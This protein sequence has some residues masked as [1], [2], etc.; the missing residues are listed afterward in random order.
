MPHLS[1]NPY[2]SVST[3]RG[4]GPKL[5]QSLAKLGI[6]RLIDLLLHLPYRYQDRTQ[7]T[8]LT[9]VRAEET[10]L[11]EGE[12]KDCRVVFGN[13]R[14][15]KVTVKDGTGTVYLRFFHFS[16][17]Q[18]KALQEAQSIRAFGEFR[19]FGRELS[20]A[21][22]EYET[23]D[24]PPNDVT[25]ELVPIY[26]TTQGLGQ[27]RL[28]KILSELCQQ[29]WPEGS[30]FEHLVYLHTPPPEATEATIASARETLAI[31]ELTA[32]Y[33]VMK[34]RALARQSTAAIPLPRSVALGRVLLDQLGFK[35]TQ[36]Q[37]R[38]VG[39]VLSDLEKPTPMLR[40]VQGDVGSGKTVVAAFAA[41]RAAEQNCQTAVMAPTELLAEQHYL[42]FVQW[43]TPLGIECVLLTGSQSAKEQK[44]RLKAVAD[45]DAL[46]VIGTHALFQDRVSFKQLGLSII[47]EQ[48]RFG[49]HQRMALQLKGGTQPHQLIMTATPIPRTLTMALYADMAV[50]VI[51][52]LPKG[53][54]PITTHTV[55]EDRSADVITQLRQAVARGQQAYWVCVLIED[56]DE[57]DAK[58]ATSRYQDLLQELKGVRIA[59]LHGRMSGDEK[60]EVM[61]RFKAGDL[62]LL[63]ATTVIEVG[64]DVPNAT[65]MVIEN[66]ERLGLAQLHQLRGRI[67]RG[68]LAS[69][70]FLLFTQRLSEAAKTRL[71]ALRDSQDGFYLAEQD[72][73]LRGPGDIL[74]TRQSGEQSFR[75]AD[76][77]EHAHLIP[78]AVS[79]G[80]EM[81]GSAERAQEMRQILETWAPADSGNLTV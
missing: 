21:H 3:I 29:A 4:V 26:P 7:L 78:R 8:P 5:E 1:A 80:D 54:Q 69:H 55:V 44:P 28:R 67:G 33:L 66:A 34:G 73:K 65:H 76:L 16:R 48:H 18:Q 58:S 74:G 42:N 53:R 11:I 43:L 19:F 22:P 63:V 47:D 12:I 25:P 37:A 50:S 46:V 61:N 14:S 20:C 45:G 75:I 57:I 56:S 31:E 41:I 68:N 49:V 13:R 35:L 59:L 27:A 23:F 72:L 15:L 52:E 39:E 51:D 70:C 32:Y 36:A 60:A 71:S 17:Y 6:F 9:D 2:A 64:V 38:V 10:H 62:D 81:M 40:L 79:L 30:P 24:H 77:S